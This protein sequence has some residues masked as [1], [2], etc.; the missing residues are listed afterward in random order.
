MASSEPYVEAEKR[1][2]AH[3]A[4]HND[5]EILPNDMTVEEAHAAMPFENQPTIGFIFPFP[6]YS[7]LPGEVVEDVQGKQASVPPF[8]IYHPPAARLTKPPEGEKESLVHKAQRKMEEEQDGARG[9]TGVKAKAVG[10]SSFT[11]LVMPKLNYGFHQL[12][13]KG[14]SATKSSG[15]EFLARTPNKKKLKEVSF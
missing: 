1:E 4:L 14:M 5:A 15:V 3:E 9:K 12:I 13:S 2:Q 7:G 6:Q 10:V 8:I 11:A